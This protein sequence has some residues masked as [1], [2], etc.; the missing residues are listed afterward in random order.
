MS[1]PATSS[2]TSRGTWPEVEAAAMVEEEVE[3]EV[4]KED[5]TFHCPMK[6]L[7]CL[8]CLINI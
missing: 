4:D 2:R 8:L 7:L 1:G 5:D 6:F 3:V